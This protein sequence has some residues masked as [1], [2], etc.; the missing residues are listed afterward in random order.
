MELVNSEDWLYFGVKMFFYIL[1]GSVLW[2]F[3][4]VYILNVIE[5]DIEMMEIKVLN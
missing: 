1:K 2:I 5:E 3:N 4:I